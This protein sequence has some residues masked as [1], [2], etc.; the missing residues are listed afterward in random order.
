M[1]ESVEPSRSAEGEAPRRDSPVI[2]TSMSG[3]LIGL[4][5]FDLDGTLL[6]GPTVCEIL[7]EALGRPERMRE[8]EKVASESALKA[9]R[10]DRRM[11]EDWIIR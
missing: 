11:R 1:A 8:R 10:P 6:R 4:A 3:A 9:A 7:A 2:P 5:V